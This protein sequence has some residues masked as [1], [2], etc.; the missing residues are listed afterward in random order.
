MVT[1]ESYRIA[2]DKRF[3][4]LITYTMASRT[5]VYY[6]FELANPHRTAGAI[7]TRNY[8]AAN[9]IVGISGAHISFYDITPTNPL[10][11]EFRKYMQNV[12][13]NSGNAAY[14]KMADVFFA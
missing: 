2:D 8:G 4:T 14:T 5:G 10:R 13:Y 1:Y 12:S 3:V 9:D 6:I 11:P 7:C